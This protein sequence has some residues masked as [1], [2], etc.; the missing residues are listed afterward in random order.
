MIMSLIYTLIGWI[1]AQWRLKKCLVEDI[2]PGQ[3]VFQYKGKTYDQEAFIALEVKSIDDLNKK[4]ISQLIDSLESGLKKS[5][6][7]E[8]DKVLLEAYN[9]AY[10]QRLNKKSKLKNL[11]D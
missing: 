2:K 9:I 8:Y 4:Q 11:F 1:Q 5:K 6:S 7:P 3:K 10:Q